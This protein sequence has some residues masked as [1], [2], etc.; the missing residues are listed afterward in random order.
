MNNHAAAHITPGRQS[1]LSLIELMVAMVI[2]L[3]V[4]LAIFSV[5]QNFE[6]RKRTSTSINDIDQAGNYAAFALDKLV[7]S[8]GSGISQSD[9]AMFGCSLT[10]MIDGAQILPRPAAL[11]APFAAVNTGTAN[12]FKLIPALIAPGQTTP[13][14]SGKPSDVLVLMS[15]NGGFG[16]VATQFTGAPAAGALKVANTIG[17]R[18]SDLVLINSVSAGQTGSPCLIEQVI[19]GFLG[20]AGGETTTLRLGLGR[21][22]PPPAPPT[23]YYKDTINGKAIA[24][25]TDT[26]NTMVLNLGNVVDGNPPTFIVV[27]VGDNNT[28]F[29]F[30]LLHSQNP[31]KDGNQASF[32]IADNIFELHALYGIDANND[33]KIDTWNAATG[34]YTPANLTNGTVDAFKRLKTIKAIRIGL[35]TRTALLEK[36]P[37]ADSPNPISPAS[38]VL[39]ADIAALTNIAALK[40]TRTLNTDI[41]SEERRYRYKTIETTIPLRNQIM[42]SQ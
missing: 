18:D 12:V 32:P 42:I 7:R 8:A 6:G 28:L 26:S 20:F 30:D 41:T 27:G 39:F 19:A 25:Y 38:L 22:R 15:G 5:L 14:V 17:F 1:G 4:S 13:S 3:I 34:D 33:G 23:L 9:G 2:G 21:P 24:N 40:V 37:A 10:A 36:V 29:G 11:P 35:I 31:T 16:E